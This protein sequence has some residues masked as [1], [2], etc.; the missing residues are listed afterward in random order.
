MQILFSSQFSSLIFMLYPDIFIN[1]LRDT[2]IGTGSTAF[3]TIRTLLDH[4]VEES[5]IIFLTFLVA[6]IGGIPVLRRAFPKVKIITGAIDNEV[7]EIQ[8]IGADGEKRKDW[9]IHPGLG[10]IGM[11]S[12]RL[13]VLGDVGLMLNPLVCL[14]IAESRYC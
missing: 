10:D 4:G 2:Q 12:S 11:F 13:I 7:K 1:I 9:E 3:M 14:L 6:R 5:H 8:R